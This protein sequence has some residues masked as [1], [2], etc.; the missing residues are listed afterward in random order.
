MKVLLV[1]DKDEQLEIS[2]PLH[3]LSEYSSFKN[4]DGDFILQPG[5]KIIWPYNDSK[6]YEVVSMKIYEHYLFVHVKNP[7]MNLIAQTIN[8]EGDKN[9]QDAIVVE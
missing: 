2:Y 8:A 3:S 9:V 7:K 1:N 4:D 6:T 5:Q